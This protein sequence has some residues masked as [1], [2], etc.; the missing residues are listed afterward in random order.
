MKKYHQRQWRQPA[1]VMKKA[2][3]AIESKKM[4]IIMKAIGVSIS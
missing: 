3:V 2:N 4:K 1:N